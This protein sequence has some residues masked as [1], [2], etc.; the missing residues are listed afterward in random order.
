MTYLLDGTPEQAM[1]AFFDHLRCAHAGGL[2]AERESRAALVSLVRLY[3]RQAA[4]GPV[5]PERLQQFRKDSAA[6]LASSNLVPAYVHKALFLA[7][8]ANDNQWYELSM[9]RSAAIWSFVELH[10]RS[11]LA[12]LQTVVPVGDHARS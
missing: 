8:S 1:N 2:D 10:G 5:S 12:R 6:A 9:R 4:V 7:E 3:D 11:G